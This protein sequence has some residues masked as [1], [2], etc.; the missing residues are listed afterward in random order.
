M[1]NISGFYD[2][3]HTDCRIMDQ[4]IYRAKDLLALRGFQHHR[5][6]KVG[7]FKNF[8]KEKEHFKLNNQVF[9][10]EDNRYYLSATGQ[11]IMY[12][13]VYEKKDN[14]YPL[15]WYDYGPVW[16]NQTKVTK[17]YLRCKQISF[18]FEAHAIL[19]NE[20]E[21][22]SEFKDWVSVLKDFFKL[23]G[24]KGLTV[25]E[26]PPQDKFKGAESTF[27][28]D[29][30]I[31]ENTYQ[32]GSI[33]YLGQNFNNA[34]NPVKQSTFGYCWGFSERL[35]GVL[36]M[37]YG[38]QYSQLLQSKPL[39][40][41][42]KSDLSLTDVISNNKHHD[43]TVAYLKI[44]KEDFCSRTFIKYEH[45]WAPLCTIKVGKLEDLNPETAYCRVLKDR[46]DIRLK[47]I[48]EYLK[49]C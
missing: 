13:I 1:T 36:K 8:E 20:K 25:V 14:F 34:Y 46:L 35:L 2:Y 10:L 17:K 47:D 21:A 39:L 30:T 27:A 18:F 19:T 6:P 44:K 49:S 43:I 16:R 48:R 9:K 4:I 41:Y 5:Y 29:C 11:S 33:H 24:L 12:P 40:V 22:K 45:M 31:G 15:K 32:I 38:Q 23:I 7:L 26:R 3:D 28:F 42:Y 37:Q